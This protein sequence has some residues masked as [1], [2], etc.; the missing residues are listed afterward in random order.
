MHF[1]KKVPQEFSGIFRK[2]STEDLCYER[3]FSTFWKMFVFRLFL[4][5]FSRIWTECSDLLHKYR[6]Q[7]ECGKIRTRK[8]PNAGTF[9]AVFAGNSVGQMHLWVPF[10]NPLTTNFSLYLETSELTPYPNQLTG[11]YMM[12]A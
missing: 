11:F 5:V 10:F 1:N 2:H 4:S 3:L 7:S 6:I 8:T 12:R 9:Y